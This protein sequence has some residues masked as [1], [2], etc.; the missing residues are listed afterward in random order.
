MLALVGKCLKIACA[1]TAASSYGFFTCC[2][3]SKISTV[4]SL[5]RVPVAFGVMPDDLENAFLNE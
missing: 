3:V 2:F 1:T 5:M 4:I